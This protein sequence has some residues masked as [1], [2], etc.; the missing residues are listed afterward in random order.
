MHEIDTADGVGGTP[1]AVAAAAQMTGLSSAAAAAAEAPPPSGLDCRQLIAALEGVVSTGLSEMSAR[2]EAALE[3]QGLVYKEKLQQLKNSLDK[4]HEQLAVHQQLLERNQQQLF[5]HSQELASLKEEVNNKTAAIRSEVAGCRQQLEAVAASQG[6]MLEQLSAA[7]EMQLQ[8][9]G[10]LQEQARG[11]QGDFGP[12]IKEQQG[13]VEVQLH[14]IGAGVMGLQQHSEQLQR[15]MVGVPQIL[16]DMIPVAPAVSMETDR[17]HSAHGYG[18]ES[19]ADGRSQGKGGKEVGLEDMDV[20]DYSCSQ[21]AR[22]GSRVDTEEWQP[23]GGALHAEPKSSSR[24]GRAATGSM[25]RRGRVAPAVVADSGGAEPDEL[26]ERPAAPLSHLSF[27]EASSGLGLPSRQVGRGGA[28]VAARH[29]K[30][31]G[32]EQQQVAQH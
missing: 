21:G 26:S 24:S 4:Q 30:Q 11:W 29:T 12:W 16:R 18:V 23:R 19:G 6:G 15:S 31:A 8:G 5:D 32:R 17:R 7:A 14:D 2:V 3:A 28:K 13:K 25:G 27:G 22:D 9:L 20:L 10:R 1:S